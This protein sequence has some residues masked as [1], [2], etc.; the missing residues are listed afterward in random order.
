M[1]R[2]IAELTTL[3]AYFAIGIKLTVA[4]ERQ[5]LDRSR[6]DWVTPLLDA[7]RFTEAGKRLRKQ[8]L[9]FWDLGLLVIVVYWLAV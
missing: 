8:A 2:L 9:V 3:V 4:A 5:L 1:I 7:S 6:S